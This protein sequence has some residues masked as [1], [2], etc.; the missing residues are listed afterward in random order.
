MPLVNDPGVRLVT[1]AREAGV[2]VHVL[3]GPSAVTTALVASGL[4]DDGYRFLGWLPRREGER[5]ALWAELS[6]VAVPA[7]A[8]ESPRRLAAS[9]ASLASREPLR[10]AAVCRELTKQHEEVVRGS[11]ADLAA[12]FAG[13]TRG[14]VTV[15]I[16]PASR[17]EASQADLSTAAAAVADL[18][19]AGASRRG[20]ADVVARL[21]HVSRNALYR[22]SL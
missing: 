11:A 1:A 7:V 4:V 9:L 18:V 6:G 2:E 19:A 16:G 5:A 14:E 10:I 17:T 13:V 12:R 20:A 21:T 8:F 3:P 15:V 22:A